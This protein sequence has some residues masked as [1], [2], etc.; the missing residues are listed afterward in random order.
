MYC[1]HGAPTS[2]LGGA[3]NHLAPALAL[4]DIKTS[5]LRGVQDSVALR[6]YAEVHGLKFQ[7]IFSNSQA[8]IGC[9]ES[10]NADDFYILSYL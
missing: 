8:F 7:E 1:I 10:I 9:F 4:V 6:W 5:G 2:R 3:P